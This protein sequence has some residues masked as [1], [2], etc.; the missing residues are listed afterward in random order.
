MAI[1][2]GIYIILSASG[3]FLMK[4][5]FEGSAVAIS[6]NLLKI[7]VNPV[8][9][10]GMLCYIASFFMFIYIVGKNN[11]SY[12]FPISA[13]IM[14]IV[15]FALGALVLKEPVSVYSVLGVALVTAGVVLMNLKMN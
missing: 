3:L 4:L 13:G 6:R 11:I 14:N 12:I 8:L 15:T 5:G 10:L 2:F 7:D 9:L 1:L